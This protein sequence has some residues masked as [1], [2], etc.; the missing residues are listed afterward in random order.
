MFE[1]LKNRYTTKV[2]IELNIAMPHFNEIC[3]EK[4]T[5][6]NNKN[7]KAKKNKNFQTKP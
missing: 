5:R 7:K 1:F 4:T 2:K 3:M 6:K